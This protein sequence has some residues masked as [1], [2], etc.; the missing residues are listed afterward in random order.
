[1]VPLIE[2]REHKR[3]HLRDGSFAG[4]YP[5]IGEIIDISLGGIL[6]NYMEF[7]DD[8]SAERGEFVICGDDGKC[9]SSLPSMVVS[10]RVLANESSF[11]KIITRQRRIMF[12]A[13]TEDQRHILHG[14]IHSHKVC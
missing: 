11:S 14:F 10:D 9:L 12:D 13:L 3:F 7:A 6:Y 8:T 1:M 4:S 5:N 2:R